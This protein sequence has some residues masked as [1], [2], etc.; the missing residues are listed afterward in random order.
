MA[1]TC[2]LAMCTWMPL[3]S[4]SDPAPDRYGDDD[5]G[6][7]DKIDAHVHLHGSLAAFMQRAVTD[8]FQLLTINVNYADFPP[9][10]V[11]LRDAVMLQRGFPGRVAF[12]AT[13]DAADSDTP[14]WSERTLHALDAAF[15]QGAVGVKVWKDIGMQLR[16]RDGRAVMIDDERFTPLF[17]ALSARGAVVLGHQGEPRNA[18]LPLEQMTIR[19]D[20]EY[21][22]SHPQYHMYLHP[23]WPSY[24]AQIAARD[25]WL[26]RNPRLRFVGVHLA[27][28]EWD[29]DRVADFLR[30]YPAA[31]VDLAA[32]LVHLQRQSVTQR[33]KVRR[34]FVEYQDR[35]VYGSDLAS[36]PEQDDATFASE[37]HTAWLADWRYLTGDAVLR[38]DEFE[39]SFR[40][41]GLPRKVVDKVYRDNA[42]RLFPQ[43]WRAP[44]TGALSSASGQRARAST[45]SPSCSPACRRRHPASAIM[46]ALSVQNS[47][48][49]NTIL[50]PRRAPSA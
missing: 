43:A 29:V 18:W 46:A 10:D 25:R 2:M 4:A 9:L 45:E 49:G 23:E 39:G 38:S 7:V 22:A 12:A 47:G 26:D 48:R 20:R 15:A 1:F 13:F 40:G 44:E 21:F 42:R 27:S 37:A 41:L 24:D 6:Q 16:A 14:G 3:A 17:R 19:G 33:D 28:L 31:S 8:R 32:R 11:Q 36:G 30:R 5:Y 35:I 50:A 34:F